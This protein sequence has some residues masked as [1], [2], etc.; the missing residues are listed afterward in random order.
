V[1]GSLR[2]R[3]YHRGL[4]RALAAVATMLT[5]A[6]CSLLNGTSTSDSAQGVVEKSPVRIG[7]LA[8]VDNAPVR[9]AETRGIFQRHGLGVEVKVLGSGPDALNEVKAGTLDICLINY[10]SFFEAAATGAVDAQV[11]ADAY[12]A[13][14]DSVALVAKPEAGIREPRDL[15]GKKISVHSI[16]NINELLLRE[17]LKGNGL[18]PNSASYL[19]VKFPE[20]QAALKTN[21]IDAGVL[22]EPYITR[23]GQELGAKP[24]LRLIDGPTADMPLS[25]YVAM[26]EFTQ[27]NPKTVAAFQLAMK[28][29]NALAEK[30]RSALGEVL[31]ELTKVPAESVSSLSLGRFPTSLDPTRLQRVIDLMQANGRLKDKDLRAEKLIVPTAAG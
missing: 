8:T 25:G 30:D 27:A 15:V 18:D 11:V 10:V 17:L 7:I 22:V 5:V 2:S 26:K 20:I 21:V 12:Q 29:A 24:V 28:E 6:S 19:G 13:T 14:P 16:G 23:A 4:V 9:L 3:G 1:P 31:P